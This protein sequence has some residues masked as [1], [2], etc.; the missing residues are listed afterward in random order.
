M[1]SLSSKRWIL[2]Q[3]D[4]ER[5]DALARELGV[6][7]VVAALLINRQVTTARDA[8]VFLNADLAC[9]HDPFEI[10]DMDAAAARVVRA[11]ENGETITVFCDYDVDGVTSAAFLTH[12]FRDLGVHVRHYLPERMAEGYGLNEDA[13]R[14]IRD[15]GSTLMIT[16]DCGITGHHEVRV[17]K[18]IGLDVIISDHHQVGEEGLPGAVAVLNPHRPDCD[19]PFRFLAGVGITFKLALA[20]RNA[21]HRTGWDKSRLPNMK[22]HLDLFVLGTIADVAPLT[23]ENHILSS[24]GLEVLA[25]SAKPGIVALK[26]VAGVDGSANARAVGFALGPRLNAAG[27]LGKADAGFHLLTATDLK[28]AMALAEEIDKINT[29]RKEIQAW[30]EEEAEYQIAR[31]VDLEAERVI[32]LASENFHAGVIGIVASRL[33]EKYFRPVVLIAMSEGKG[34][35]SGRSIPRFNLH[36]AFTECAGRLTQ[37]GGHAYAAGLSIE[38]ENVAAFRDA[39]NQVARRILSDDDMVPELTIDAELL[40]ADIGRPLDAAIRKLEPFGAGN[41]QPV[42]LATNV[43]MKNLRLMGKNKEHAR[44]TACQSGARI[45]AVGFGLAEALAAL[46]GEAPR[47]DLA[48][49]IQ[50]NT[51]NGQN[52][53]ELRILDARAARE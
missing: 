46:E 47:I 25:T 45:D 33:V 1:I 32:V 38:E 41:P 36:K 18:T 28:E 5:I 19:Y 51:W 20:V 30:V 24:H 52:K 14:K 49:E 6:P 53:L 11:V 16:A 27:R 9:L 26:A 48:F 44:F 3:A 42:F 23:G 7:A 39:M 50:T 17:A 15:G 43:D 10:K 22:R 4:P 35:G 29:E 34:K 8:E 2:S 12:F 13:V 37:F 40:L 31:E 21:L